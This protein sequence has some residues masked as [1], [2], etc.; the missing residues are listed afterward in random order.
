MTE[1]T[2]AQGKSGAVPLDYQDTPLVVN[3]RPGAGSRIDSVD[4]LRGI[5][6]VIMLLDHT[7]DFVHR[8]TFLFDPTDLSRTYPALFFTRWITHFC[9]PVFVFLAG[10]GSYFQ[11]VRGK[12]KA[13]LSRFL[14]TRGLWLIVLEVTLIRFLVTWEYGLSFL[15]MLQV[16][17]VIGVG[18]IILAGLIHLPLRVIATFGIAM[19]LLHNGL[20]GMRAA[21]WQGPGTVV[22]LGGKLW[23]L[24]HQQGAFP[25][26]G[27]PSPI[28]FV[29]YPLIPW[30]GVMAA[31][32][33]FGSIY[34]QPPEIR[35]VRLMRW[36]VAIT[37][38]FVLLRLA[39]VY[40]DH[41]GWE[42][43]KTAAMTVVS[44]F[45]TQKYPPSLLY[46][47]MTLG[48]ALIG[49]SLWDGYNRASGEKP[50]RS[51]FTNALI[52]YG[53]VPLFFYICQWIWAHASGYFLTVASGKS[54]DF[55]VALP[56]PGSPVPKDAGLDVWVVY[57][58]WSGGAVASYPL[59]RWYAGLKA[60]RKDWW[61]SY[62]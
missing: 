23:M 41:N 25:V 55:Y 28:L 38:G 3:P 7:R 29:L 13:E 31:G 59:C 32:Y 47:A 60:R 52:T 34:D 24:L 17:W 46:L 51:W 57:V 37:I 19:I 10:T 20:D 15:G 50:A 56:G 11:I 27:W 33:A 21:P 36:G 12:S 26:G 40:G 44:F 8:D 39:D 58:V 61:L 6:M 9:A 30:V 45:N 62:L 18:M 43:Q 1:S 5:V 48:P 22:S 14:I 35:R 42:P 4:L 16:I 49:L 54:A 2:T 53:R